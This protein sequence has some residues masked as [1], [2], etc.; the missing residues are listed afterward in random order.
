MSL[1][2]RLEYGL[3]RLASHSLAALACR[4]AVANVFWRSGQTKVEGASVFGLFHLPQQIK[5]STF[6]LFQE[7]YKVPLLNSDT[8]AVLAT[9]AE[10]LFPVLLVLGLFTRF[11]AFA[12]LGM[13]TVIQCFV[14]PAA[15][16]VHLQWAGLLLA[17]L[18]MGGGRWSFDRWWRGV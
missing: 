13:T 14:Y 6:T 15:W 16:P 7:E 1:L 4:L 2:T 10:H 3:A 5:D 17:L 9:T 18:A 11:S 8:A 12:L